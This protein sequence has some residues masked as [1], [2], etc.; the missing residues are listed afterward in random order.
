M[1]TL[2]L[3][4]RHA[5]KPGAIERA[6]VALG[7]R[8]RGP[9][10]YPA[11]SA[12][13]VQCGNCERGFRRVAGVHIGSQRLGMIPDSPCQRVFAT[14][15]GSDVKPWMAYVDGSPVC[16]SLGYARRFKTARAAYRAALLAAPKRWHE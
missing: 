7:R 9:L 1:R 16:T 6:A 11:H 3:A 15:G 14:H 2:N 10:I 8:E 5:N 13:L 12:G 4:R